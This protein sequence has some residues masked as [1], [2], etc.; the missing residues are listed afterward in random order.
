MDFKKKRWIYLFAG[1]L[2]ELCAGLPYAWSVFQN[3]L[4]EKYGWA[5]SSTGAA[6]SLG[7]VA[8]LVFT[9]TTA[10]LLMKRAG[11]R[12]FLLLGSLLY[13]G[14]TLCLGFIQ[15][16]L[17][18]LYF[19]YGI[20]VC[21]GNAILYPTLTSYAV[22]LFP[23][24][25]GFASGMMVAGFGC[26]PFVMSPLIAYIYESAGD[27]SRAFIVL[28]V[29]FL[30]L[31]TALCLI[32]QEPPAEQRKEEKGTS[33]EEKEIAGKGAPLP[34]Q[35][36]YS[37]SQMVKTPLFYLLYATFAIGITNGTMLLTQA[38]PILQ[39]N[40]GLSVATAAG[41]V[42][43]IS[44]SNTLGRLTWGAVS[45]KLGRGN[46]LLLMHL[47]FVAGF[48]LL[49][50][51]NLQ[52]CIAALLLNIFC[53]GGFS[54]LLAPT[55]SQVFGATTLGENYSIMFSIFSVAGILGPTL[56]TIGGFT[57]ACVSGLISSAA[58][59]ALAFV[60]RRKAKQRQALP[61]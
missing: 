55:T 44:L 33:S 60:F 42:S 14:G 38:S 28:G 52:A 17:W 46:A 10:A 47:L 22:R 1:M 3:L 11:L 58:G 57:L 48:A 51:P 16:N 6:Y 30:L 5:I 49:F 29:G 36:Q 4:A 45:D 20:L 24:R 15:G 26:G 19:Y 23:D 8:M 50:V 54:A 37:R 34:S 59:V 40:F 41:A 9:L 18:E 53:F 21:V 27:I 35:K 2:I 43:L 32:L 31:V 7:G 13:G 25:P 39:S 61:L 12:K 56:V